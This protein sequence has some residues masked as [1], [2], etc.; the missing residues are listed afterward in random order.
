MVD[1]VA[2]LDLV[3]ATTYLSRLGAIAGALLANRVDKRGFPV[4]PFR[5]RV[6]PARGGITNDRD[7]KWNTH[8]STS[9]LFVYAMAAFARR[10]LDWP[11]QYPQFENQ[12]VALV[13]AAFETYQA[14]R[15][16]SA[17]LRLLKNAPITRTG[18]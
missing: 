17:V 1:L 2:P 14:F 10:V 15:R 18:K 8:A 7:C 3:R 13:T 12:A 9:G 16:T 6:M 11:A 5:G 4:D